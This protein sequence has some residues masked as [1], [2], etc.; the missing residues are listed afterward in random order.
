MHLTKDGH[1]LVS[2]DPDF[3]RL[4]GLNKK[5]C[6]TNLKDVPERFSNDIPNFFGCD[7][8][9]L[10]PGDKCEFTYSNQFDLLIHKSANHPTYILNSQPEAMTGPLY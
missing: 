7:Y 1:L 8:Y 10:K 9:T 6:D 5:V 2:H 3:K 4:C